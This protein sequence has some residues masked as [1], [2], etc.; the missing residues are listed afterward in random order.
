MKLITKSHDGSGEPC[1]KEVHDMYREV[2]QTHI[3]A[4][5]AMNKA[6]EEL[7]YLHDEPQKSGYETSR[8][9]RLTLTEQTKVANSELW[10][11]T[12]KFLMD[13]C[14]WSKWDVRTVWSKV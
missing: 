8:S 13:E 9:L 1:E 14:G 11:C 4:M 2:V 5:R 12:G 7:E 10:G 6:I 3:Y